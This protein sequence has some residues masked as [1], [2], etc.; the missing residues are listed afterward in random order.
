MLKYGL[1]NDTGAGMKESGDLEVI[2]RLEETLGIWLKK[3]ANINM[4]MGLFNNGYCLDAEGRVVGLN[5]DGQKKIDLSLLRDLPFLSTLSLIGCSLVDVSP[6]GALTSLT[7]LDLEGNKV[8]DVSPLGALTSLTSLNLGSNRVV[9]VSPLGALTSLTSLDLKVNEVADVSPLGTLTQLTSLDISYNKIKI[10][11]QWVR[12]FKG[13]ITWESS[14]RYGPPGLFLKFNP[15]EKPPIEVVKEGKDAIINYFKELEEDSVRFLHAKV[16]LVG[17]GEVGKTTLMKKILDPDHT[18]K[19]GTED[20]T[21]G[22]DIQPWSIQCTLEDDSVEDITVHFWDFG[23][24]EIYHSTHQ[25]FLTKRSLYLFVWDARKEE[26]PRAFDYW[27]EIIRLLGQGSPIIMVMNKADERIINVDEKSLIN[28]FPN[29]ENFHKVSC[30]RGDGLPPLI[31]QVRETLGRLPH[32]ADTLP[33]SW[34]EIRNALTKDTRDYITLEEYYR[35]CQGFGLGL[36]R[37]DFLSGYLHDLGVILH[38]R[39]D[40]VLENTVILKPQWATEAV[41]K[42]I[43]TKEIIQNHGRFSFHGLKTYWAPE[44]YPAALHLQLVRLM[45]R[46][47]LCFNYT[48]TDEYFVPELLPPE[49]PEFDTSLYNGSR[50]LRFEYRYRFMPVGIISRFISRLSYLIHQRRS[51]KNGVE[52]LFENTTALVTGQPRANRVR[53]AVTGPCRGKLLGIIQSNLEH[54][55]STL[56]MEINTHYRQMLP[57]TCSLCKK[58]ASPHFYNYEVLTRH[59]EKNRTQVP[60]DDSSED[61]LIETLLNGYTPPPPEKSLLDSLLRASAFLTGLSKTIKTDEDSRTGFLRL[62]VSLD[63][64]DAQEQARWGKSGT[65]KSPGRVD[66]LVTLPETGRKAACEAFNLASRD[67]AVIDDHLARVFY[68][69]PQGSEENFILVY[70]HSKDFSALWRRYLGYLPQRDDLYPRISGPKEIKTQWLEIKHA[71]TVHRREEGETTLHHIF[72]NML[73]K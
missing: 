69:D 37:A 46:F 9:D 11:P 3:W 28:E 32:L 49:Q 55:H 23:G 64:F 24:Q 35:I 42:L 10:L 48:H 12:G 19:P 73:P 21:E 50:A 20:T 6:L 31:W 13:E 4:V 40:K 27:L 41:Y 39:T 25:F 54:I 63:G 53:V 68:Y 59:L 51:W 45:E 56:N 17:Q 72:V 1:K 2:R 5:L 60:C 7:S 44:K 30:V 34:L 14:S 61:V 52:L 22:I 58:A 66:L 47:E 62:M 57:C 38:F 8:V 36:E 29:I 43:D 67:T 70:S 71:V 15:L 18:V 33:A 65:G 16:L 26:D